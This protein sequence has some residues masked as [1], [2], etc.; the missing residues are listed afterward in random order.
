MLD[1]LFLFINVYE[2]GSF[3]LAAEQLGISP[4]T[5]TRRV[6]NLEYRLNCQLIIR[7]TKSLVLTE[8]GERLYKE[9]S[10][11]LKQVTRQLDHFQSDMT[12]FAGKIRL[13]APNNLSRSFLAPMVASFMA[14]HPKIDIAIYAGSQ[15]EALA[16][17]R[18]DIAIR[19]QPEPDTN[20]RSCKLITLPTLLVA[21]VDFAS[22]LQPAES[23][24][25]I[26]QQ[27][28]VSALKENQ[29]SLTQIT[30]QDEHKCVICPRFFVNDLDTGLRMLKQFPGI[31]LCPISEAASFIERGE[32]VQVYPDWLGTPREVYA[33]WNAENFMLP[34][35][36]ALLDHF[37]T[38]FEH[39][40]R[41]L[42]NTM[43]EPASRSTNNP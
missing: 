10:A 41:Q 43:A 3:R 32:L 5:L 11:L 19:V 37:K 15:I 17:H 24:D 30:T 33:L 18:A 13:L 1:D 6:Q 38:C 8:S 28:T 14:S 29:I 20:L 36:R 42:L 26:A 27:I 9:N 39:K 35:T 4:A 12:D 25:V 7:S 22:N 16:T 40:E 31:M 23:V 21:P 34:R 2:S